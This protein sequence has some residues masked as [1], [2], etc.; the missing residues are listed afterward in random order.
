MVLS[1]KTIR[2]RLDARSVI[3]TPLDE[4]D[5]QPS[6]IDLHLAA[7]ISVFQYM[8][9]EIIDVTADNSHLLSEEIIPPDKPFLLQPG[10]FALASTVESVVIPHDL[11]ASLDGKSSL[12]RLGLL[13]HATAGYIDPGFRG[14]ITLELSNDNK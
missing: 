10:D 11:K 3:I 13:V 9:G 4:N 8:P 2:D 14:T 5:I 7:E 6:S 12:G 1:D